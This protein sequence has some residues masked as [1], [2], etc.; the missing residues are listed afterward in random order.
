[1]RRSY[2]C[3]VVA[4]LLVLLSGCSPKEPERIHIGFIGPLTGNA[5]DMGSGAAR[6]ITLAVSEYN[7]R[8]APHEPEVQLHVKND[9]WDG[10]NAKPLYD[11]LRQEHDIKVLLMSHTDGTI[12]LQ[13]DIA[14]DGVVLINSLNNDDLLAGLNEYTFTVGKKTEEAAQLVAG[15]VI[16]LGKRTI[17]GFHVD[18]NFMTIFGE[19]FTE[20]VSHFGVD[21]RLV[22]VGIEKEDY[23]E[24]LMAFK[25][26]GCD[27]LV[28]FG[29]KNLGY[30]MKQA[31]E[32]GFECGFFGSTTMLGKGFFENSEGAQVGTEFSY[33]TEADGN[34]VI[35]RRFLDRYQKKF[36]DLPSAVWPAM[37]AYDAVN[38]ALSLIKKW[39]AS[40]QS[41]PLAD[42]LRTELLE[43]EFYQGVCGN[44]AMKKD[45]TSRGIYFSL[46]EIKGLE[47]VAKVRR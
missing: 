32:L 15:R 21:S 46:Y 45:G 7:S 17:R 33:F 40:T 20:E 10:N 2:V 47:E 25:E 22:S 35:A 5:E 41:I 16:E 9:F 11:E 12:A 8:R 39:A 30:A 44:L 4:S 29:Y 13:E 38:I 43:L 3:L 24:D 23:R 37:Q 14:R 28:F 19:S 26:E 36:D 6:A 1:M 34:Y 27:A 42:Y 31:R 18:N